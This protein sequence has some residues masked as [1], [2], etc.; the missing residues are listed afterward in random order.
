MHIVDTSSRLAL[1]R[2]MKTARSQLSRAAAPA[3]LFYCVFRPTVRNLKSAPQRSSGE[4]ETKSVAQIC[5][6]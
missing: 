4:L 2:V 5:S 3:F 6:S 1:G